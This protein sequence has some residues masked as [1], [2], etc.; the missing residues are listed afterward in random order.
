MNRTLQARFWL[1]AGTVIG[2][3]MLRL[4]RIRPASLPIARHA[5]QDGK[6]ER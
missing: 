5:P 4:I 6:E 1:M 3:A 2:A